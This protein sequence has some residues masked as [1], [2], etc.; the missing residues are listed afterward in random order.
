M[1]VGHLW[2]FQ[3]Q[4]ECWLLLTGCLWLV[5]MHSVQKQLVLEQLV[6]TNNSGIRTKSLLV[7]VAISDFGSYCGGHSVITSL[8]AMSEA[9]CEFDTYS[10]N[11]PE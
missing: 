4:H 9:I 8:E 1:R 10:G 5:Q 6:R 2:R 3:V 11:S 7:I